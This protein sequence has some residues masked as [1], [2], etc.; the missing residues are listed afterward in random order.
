MGRNQRLNDWMDPE[1]KFRFLSINNFAVY[2]GIKQTAV[3]D[4]VSSKRIDS[5]TIDGRIWIPLSFR[6]SALWGY[7]PEEESLPNSEINWSLTKEKP[8]N[9]EH[10][11]HS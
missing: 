1:K 10:K 4:L 11:K 5:L 3:M 2:L 6:Y 7:V 8:E 9:E